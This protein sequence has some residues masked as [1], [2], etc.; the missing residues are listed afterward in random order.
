MPHDLRLRGRSCGRLPGAAVRSCANRRT[1]S[2]RLSGIA[3]EALRLPATAPS[4]CGARPQV[5]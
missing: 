2:A 3:H 4:W 1:A 5:R